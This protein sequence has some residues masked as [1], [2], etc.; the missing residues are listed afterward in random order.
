M[1]NITRKN[2]HNWIYLYS[3]LELYVHLHRHK[4]L[5]HALGLLRNRHPEEPLV[6]KRLN[7]CGH[8]VV[9]GFLCEGDEVGAGLRGCAV[10]DDRLGVSECVG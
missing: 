5:I 4:S 6:Y 2:V 3:L 8:S 7:D 1:R 9:P 10:P